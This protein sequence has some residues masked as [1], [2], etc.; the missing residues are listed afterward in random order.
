MTS[1][2]YT[3]TVDSKIYYSTQKRVL[4]IQPSLSGYSYL[5]MTFL[6]YISQYSGQNGIDYPDID[7]E[8]RH[9]IVT[10]LAEL[11]SPL[12]AKQIF[13][14]MYDKQLIRARGLRSK[15]NRQSHIVPMDPF[16]TE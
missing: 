11:V 16:A 2:R 1:T 4:Y 12:H 13:T 5:Y 9:L 6:P 7:L 3:T 8:F 10:K 15:Q 14:T